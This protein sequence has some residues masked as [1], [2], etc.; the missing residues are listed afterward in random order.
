MKLDEATIGSVVKIN[1]Y[2]EIRTGL[3]INSYINSG[4]EKLVNI[5]GLEYK[6]LNPFFASSK[7]EYVLDNELIYNLRKKAL[8]LGFIKNIKTE[9]TTAFGT[10]PVIKLTINGQKRLK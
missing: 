3:V 6:M 7:A 4:G 2:G 8:E 5:L 10:V 1:F 9:V